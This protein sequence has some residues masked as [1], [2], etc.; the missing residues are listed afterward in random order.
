MEHRPIVDQCAWPAASDQVI[1]T[2]NQVL[3]MAAK[4][5]GQLSLTNSEAYFTAV[6]TENLIRICSAEG[7]A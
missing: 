6:C 3:E 4:R 5:F 2:I 7:I 1:E